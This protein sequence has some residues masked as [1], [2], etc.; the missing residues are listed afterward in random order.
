[1]CEVKIPIPDIEIQRSIVNTY[2]AYLARRAINEKMKSQIKDLLE[3]A[4][5]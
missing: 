3:D 5:A 4:N 2:N 1:M